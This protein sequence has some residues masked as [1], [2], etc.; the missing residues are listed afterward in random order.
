MT[1]EARDFRKKQK[2]RKEKCE[3][4]IKSRSKKGQRSNATSYVSQSL[5]L[6]TASTSNE[7]PEKDI[8]TYHSS[9]V[10]IFMPK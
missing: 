2:R 1:D 9:F 10:C 5:L 4:E 6:K 3:G 7:K 8:M